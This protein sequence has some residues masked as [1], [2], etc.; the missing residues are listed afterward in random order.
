[1]LFLS[2]LLPI[3]IYPL[4]FSCLLLIVSLILWWKYPRFVPIPIALAL[5]VLWLSSNGWFSNWIVQSLEWQNIPQG[6]LP[7]AE[8]IV[9]LGG[10]TK[11]ADAPRPMV[12]VNEQGDRVTYGAK[13]YRDGKAPLIVAAGGRVAWRG[14]GR[15]EAMDM[16]ELLMMMGVPANAILKETESLNTYENAVNVKVILA[17]KGI[18]KVLLV[19]SALHMPRSISIFHNQAIEAIAAPTDFLVSDRELAEPNASME[20]FVLNL[21]PDVDRL[22]KTSKAIKEYIGLLIYRLKGWA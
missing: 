19:T 12:D 4:G 8:A 7:Q 22:D 13:L 17:A 10:A 6:D 9:I 2:K 18:K 20:A 16:A 14:G 15:A 1:M 21:L 11:S 3:F 5:I